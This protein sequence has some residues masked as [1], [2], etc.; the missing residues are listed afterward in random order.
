MTQM[1]EPHPADAARLIVME[2]IDGLPLD[3]P[4]Y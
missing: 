2:W 3:A 4:R 1:S